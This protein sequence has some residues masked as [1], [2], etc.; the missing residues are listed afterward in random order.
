[1]AGAESGGRASG[2]GGRF[3]AARRGR[4]GWRAGAVYI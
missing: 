1:V 3:A 2:D 4:A